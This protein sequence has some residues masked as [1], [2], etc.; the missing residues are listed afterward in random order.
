MTYSVNDNSQERYIIWRL[1]LVLEKLL[2]KTKQVM[3]YDIPAHKHKQFVS[4]F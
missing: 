4:K 3:T 2:F 1:A